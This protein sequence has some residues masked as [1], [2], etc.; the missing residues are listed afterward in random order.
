[1]TGTLFDYFSNLMIS[2]LFFFHSLMKASH[3][4]VSRCMYLN[5]LLQTK[6]HDILNR[7]VYMAKQDHG[8]PLL[9]FT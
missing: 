8:A 5:I 4:M 7:Y 3:K 2:W 9:V 1:M 6:S